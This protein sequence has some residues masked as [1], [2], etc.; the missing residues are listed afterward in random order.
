MHLIH[1]SSIFGWH[2]IDTRPEPHPQHP[3]LIYIKCSW[4][5]AWL[6]SIFIESVLLAN[7]RTFRCIFCM[8]GLALRVA[9]TQF[10]FFFLYHFVPIKIAFCQS[11][12]VRFQSSSVVRL[13][14]EH[15]ALSIT[16]LK[17]EFIVFSCLV[18]MPVLFAS[19][20]MT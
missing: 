12:I 2:E 19:E 3:F 18:G 14:R 5:W 20:N 11:Q 10:L 16:Q 17:A 1:I 6:T 8:F 9:E 4:C 13:R 7:I 15:G